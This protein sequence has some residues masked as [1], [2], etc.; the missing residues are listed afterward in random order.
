[1]IPSRIH[2]T[3]KMRNGSENTYHNMLI[4]SM[5]RKKEESSDEDEDED[6]L[7]SIPILV[8]YHIQEKIIQELVSLLSDLN[9]E[10]K[11]QKEYIKRTTGHCLDCYRDSSCSC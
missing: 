7:D 1:M 9:Y 5:K 4:C 10:Y 3:F 2:S 6:E 11:D 8:Q